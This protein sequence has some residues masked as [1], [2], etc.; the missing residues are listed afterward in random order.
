MG[1]LQSRPKRRPTPLASV[2]IR[3][4]A[5]EESRGNIEIGLIVDHETLCVKRI[6]DAIANYLKDCTVYEC[7]ENRRY[8]GVVVDYN[9]EA[10]ITVRR[11]AR[12]Y[13][14]SGGNCGPMYKRFNV[15]D[16]FVFLY[17]TTDVA[18]V[19]YARKALDILKYESTQIVPVLM[20]RYNLDLF[21]AWQKGCPLLCGRKDFGSVFSTLCQDILYYIASLLFV[22][23]A[24]LD[25]SSFHGPEY[26][27]Q[28]YE[29]DFDVEYDYTPVLDDY[30]IRKCLDNAIE[31]CIK[32]DLGF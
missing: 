11:E 7:D 14:S 9:M 30:S 6:N 27:V 5:S 16:V 26:C 10:L 28:C 17:K 20:V 1:S 4:A 22:L 29:N 15:G 3:T 19:V 18:N 23:H 8:R 2:K 25:K 12:R 32:T 13:E 24:P 31:H 21:D